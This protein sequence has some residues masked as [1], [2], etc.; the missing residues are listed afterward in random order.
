MSNKQGSKRAK[1]QKPVTATGLVRA[2]LHGGKP[3]Y[4]SCLRELAEIILGENEDVRLYQ[5]Q[6]RLRKAIRA[7]NLLKGRTMEGTIFYFPQVNKTLH[8]KILSAVWQR[9]KGSGQEP[10]IRI[11]AEATA[12]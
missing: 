4:A 9:P 11:D 2:F 10:S 3:I 7:R 5:V 6:S 12:A 1:N 8:Q